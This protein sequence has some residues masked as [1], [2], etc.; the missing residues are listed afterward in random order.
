MM[1]YDEFRAMNTDILVAAEGNRKD[2]LP[3][4]RQV[5][6]AID[7]Y[8]QRFSR[9]RPS[10]ELSLFNQAAGDWVA[11]S[12]DMLELL[13]EAKEAYTLTN[14]LFD[15]SVLT[16]LVAAGYD[17]SM[18]EIRLL[19]SVPGKP[20]YQPA[21]LGFEFLEFDLPNQAVWMP[22]EIQIDLGGIAKGWIAA[23]AAA[24]LAAYTPAGAVSTGGDMVL[25]GIPEGETAWEVSLEDPWDSNRVLSNLRVGPGAL[26]T[27]TVT[28]RHWKQ[29]GHERHHI[30]DPR[31]GLPSQSS[32]A[33]VTAYTAKATHAEAFAKALLIAGAEQY[34]QLIQKT[35]D[36]RFVAVQADGSLFGNIQ[37]AGR[38]S[39][40]SQEV[41]YVPNQ[42]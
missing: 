21:P 31:T 19:D 42:I 28:K 27:S 3:G 6:E 4:F 25:F 2:L 36:V 13:Q 39:F 29:G 10:S 14:G 26:A 30:I 41:R 35:P 34:Y 38:R 32:W 22:P 12:S 37:Q 18:D 40:K 15:P 7:R 17:R 1:E 24:L 23:R 16:A 11:V 5:R 33:C 20:A 9:F 8:E